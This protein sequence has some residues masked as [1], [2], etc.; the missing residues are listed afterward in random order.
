MS[1]ITFTSK[2]PAENHDLWKGETYTSL[3]LDAGVKPEEL[4]PGVGQ[5]FAS[6]RSG[7]YAVIGDKRIGEREWEPLQ[8]YLTKIAKNCG[9]VVSKYPACIE[10]VSKHLHAMACYAKY[11][12]KK[13][14]H[15]CGLAVDPAYRKHGIAKQ[16][17]M[18]SLQSIEAHG[19]LGVM[20]ETTGN[21][22][23]KVMEDLQKESGLEVEELA[24]LPYQDLIDSPKP[25]PVFRIFLIT[26]EEF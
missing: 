16:L 23:A 22:S 4:F 12:A 26:F 25:V 13:Y 20:V 17:V 24:A 14:A 19:Y 1:D 18:M 8:T 7:W 15:F 6:E 2:A 3:K 5:L 10:L 21:G 11:D 9:E